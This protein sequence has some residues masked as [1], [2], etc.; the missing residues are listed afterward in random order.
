MIFKLTDSE[1]SNSFQSRV[2]LSDVEMVNKL[3]AKS[4][5]WRECYTES[6]LY[7]MTDSQL[8]GLLQ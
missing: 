1:L 8:E 6:E 5:I 3:M 4:C 2:K 7:E